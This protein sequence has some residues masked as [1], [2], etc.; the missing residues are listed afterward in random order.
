MAKKLIWEAE[1]GKLNVKSRK[2][3]NLMMKPEDGK[4]EFGKPKMAY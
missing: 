4:Y 1:N 3:R 2:W